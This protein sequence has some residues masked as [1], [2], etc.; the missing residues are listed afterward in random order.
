MHPGPQRFI[1]RHNRAL[2]LPYALAVRPSFVRDLVAS[3]VILRDRLRTA[4]SR[5]GCTGRTSVV[6]LSIGEPASFKPWG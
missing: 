3:N 1:L 4:I 5:R 6:V 2:V